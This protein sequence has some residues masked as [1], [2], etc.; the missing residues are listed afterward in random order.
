[1]TD[2][3]ICKDAPDQQIV[4]GW[5]QV[6]KDKD[7]RILVD[8]D[9]DFISSSEELEKAA[10][11]FVLKS[12]DGGEMHVRKGVSTLVESIVFTKEKMQMM[13]I[14]EGHLPEGWF[15]GFKVHDDDVWKRVKKGEYPMFSV[16]GKGKRRRTARPQ[17]ASLAKSKTLRTGTQNAIEKARNR[18]G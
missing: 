5:A 10:Y 11:D 6:Y 8:H 9:E 12:R 2:F 13:G 1:M 16:H 7:G 17:N 4:F 14:P 15:V 18:H 3:L